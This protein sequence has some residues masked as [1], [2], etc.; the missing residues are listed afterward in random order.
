MPSFINET[1]KSDTKCFVQLWKWSLYLSTTSNLDEAHYNIGLLT[2][3]HDEALKSIMSCVSNE[4]CLRESARQ[5]LEKTN[6]SQEEILK[7]IYDEYKA[8]ELN[9]AMGDAFSQLKTTDTSNGAALRTDKVELL[10][11]PQSD[12]SS[13]LSQVRRRNKNVG[14]NM[15]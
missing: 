14:D 10:I 12:D 8:L 9:S 4:L 1:R 3:K 2:Y 7:F 15:F 5:Y 13:Q 6:R 11:N